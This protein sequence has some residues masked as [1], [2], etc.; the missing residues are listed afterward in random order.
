MKKNEF[1]EKAR[2]VH[3]YKYLYPSLSDKIIFKDKIDIIYKDILY[4]QSVSKHL[5]GRCPEKNTPSKTTE[6]FIE[7]SFLIWGN[8]YDYSLTEYKGAL[9]VVKII[10]DGVVFEQ[11]A[12]SH[13]KGLAVELKYN[14]EYFIKKSVDRWGDKYDYSL[15]DFK[16]VKSKIKIIYNETGVI[17][18]QTPSNHLMY[19]PENISLS[20]RSNTQTFIDRSNEIHN[21][22]YD[23]SMVDYTVSSNKVIIICKTHGSFSQVANSHILGMGCKKCGDYFGS[24]KREY[25]KKYTTDEFILESQRIWG[26][27]YDYSLVKYVNARTKVKI[28]YDD[29]IYEQLPMGHLK[30][31]VEGYLNQEIFLIK[32]KRKWGDKYDYSLVK[33]ISTKFTVKIIY[34]GEIYEQLPHNHLIYSPEL[35]NKLT[36]EDFI[37]RSNEIHNVKYNYNLVN[38]VSDRVKVIINCPYHGN[39]FQTPSVHLRGS[40]CRRCNDSFG[41][42]IIANFL[43]RNNIEYKREYIFDDCKNIYPLRFDFYIP[44]TRKCIEFDGIQHF[45]PVEYFGGVKAYELR[46][47][48]DKIKNDYCEDNYINLIRIRYNQIDDINN[49]LYENLKNHI[50]PKNLFN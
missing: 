7:E 15:V 27:K 24:E 34:K 20:I 47:I 21:F 43:D 28:I 30:Y 5:M 32:A 22:K 48:N 23:Y 41:E 35:K 13:L 1:L 8:K 6:Q 12:T 10:Y 31:P 46:K 17:Y 39:F 29:I 2:C 14:K 26:D 18:E 4:K 25:I 3:G 50:K 38:Y 33:Y 11:I 37:L 9:K 40:G 19:A 45:Q 49:I 44:S 36:K 42:K 16:N